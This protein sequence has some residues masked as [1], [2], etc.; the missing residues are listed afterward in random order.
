MRAT[1]IRKPNSPVV[2]LNL[3][4][5]DRAARERNWVTDLQIA[6]GLGIH[7]ANITR[8]RKAASE[9]QNPGATFIAAALHA[10]PELRFEDLFSVSVPNQRKRAA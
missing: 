6:N 3:D 5:L 8:L 7:P 2:R 1:T 10:L 9:R 4:V